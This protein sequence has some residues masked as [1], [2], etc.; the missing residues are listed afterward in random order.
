MP[1]RHCGFDESDSEPSTV[2]DQPV[3]SDQASMQHD[4]PDIVDPL[5]SAFGCVSLVFGLHLVLFLQ[6]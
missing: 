5:V 6:A 1:C 2:S 3:A 4:A